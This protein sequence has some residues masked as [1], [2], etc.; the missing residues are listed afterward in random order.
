MR[1]MLTLF[2]LTMHTFSTVKKACDFL[3]NKTGKHWEARYEMLHGE[4]FY[5][6][7]RAIELPFHQ[8]QLSLV[9]RGNKKEVL[10][11]LEKIANA[12]I[13]PSFV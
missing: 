11:K 5:F 10:A 2:F 8:R 6:V 7:W 3:V 1:Q 9:C 12:P 4:R 13:L